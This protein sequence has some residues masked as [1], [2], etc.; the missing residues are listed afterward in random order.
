MLHCFH[1]NISE[2][3]MKSTSL[4]ICDVTIQPGETAN[5]AL[6]LPDY[7][8]CTSFYMPIK[9]VHGKRP[10][11]CV[12]IFS[13]LEGNEFN[14][15][16]ICNRLL[17]LEGIKSL[18]GTLITIPIMNILAL[19]SPTTKPYEKKL[20]ECFPG[21]DKGSFGERT[22]QI[23][24]QEILSKAT[25]CVE[26]KTGG[27]N[28]DI[29]PQIY[30][31]VSNQITKN[32][33]KQFAAPVISHI[34]QSNSLRRVTSTMDM[35]LLMYK[36]GEAMRFDES[37]IR[38]GIAGIQNLLHALE[39]VDE[40]EEIISHT[41]KPVFSKE[42]EWSRAHR[43][44]IFV[45]TIS[46]GQYIKQNDIIGRITDPFNDSIVE[47][48]IAPRDG[49][50]VGINRNPLIYEGQNIF[51]IASFINNDRAELT[52]EQWSTLQETLC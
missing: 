30:C 38:I 18:K 1:G 35:P 27:V 51:N 3:I 6:P 9:V 20:E 33:A 13:G 26:L 39:M 45:A 52:L 32:L 47:E 8:S 36:A 42:Q 49:I 5:L 4:R 17:K 44:G 11:P 23:F 10:G 16:E 41:I 25:H 2:N 15:I 21:N 19:V 34:N 24:T 40:K 50:I 46:L 48:V 43:S 37:S 22:A 12:L 31:D 14:G 7:N 28:D 29:L